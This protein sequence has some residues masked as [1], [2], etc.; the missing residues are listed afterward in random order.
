MEQKHQERLKID[1][2]SYDERERFSVWMILKEIKRNKKKEDEDKSEEKL[3]KLQQRLAN[4]L[5]D[6]ILFNKPY[7]T[8]LFMQTEI[9]LHAER[10]MT[11]GKAA[12][13]KAFLLRNVVEQQRMS[14]HIY[15]E[16]LGVKLN[17]KTTYIP[18]RLG[19]LFAI[20]ERL[21]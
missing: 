11:Y 5:V 15:K 20:L 13:I 17:E 19:R 12:I 1:K 8:A 18:Y 10:K 4:E 16:V 6:S 9:C 14:A 21:L 7:P 2:P 3:T